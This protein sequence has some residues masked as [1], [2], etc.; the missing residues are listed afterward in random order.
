MP[1]LSFSAADGFSLLIMDSIAELAR[2]SGADLLIH[3]QF[4]ELCEASSSL[5]KKILSSM[6]ALIKRD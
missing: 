5:R 2:N 1:P 4:P 3:M 6:A